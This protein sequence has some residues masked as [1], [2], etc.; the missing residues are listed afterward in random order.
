MCEGNSCGDKT[1]GKSHI[2]ELLSS[3][4]FSGQSRILS[5]RLVDE[6]QK[7]SLRLKLEDF[8]ASLLECNP[9]GKKTLVW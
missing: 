5:V 8:R 9:A 6:E 4:A 7:E 2:E 1:N 3:P